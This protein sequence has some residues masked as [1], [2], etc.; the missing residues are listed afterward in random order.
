MR[1]P[2]ANTALLFLIALELLTGFA[3]LTNGSASFRW[4]VWLHGIG[5]FAI[6]A[7]LPWKGAIIASALARRRRLGIPDAAFVVLAVLLV[8][9]L[10]TGLIWTTAGR[11]LAGGYSL[12]TIHIALAAATLGLLVWHVLAMR[13]IFG[14]RGALDRRAFLRLASS[15]AA[16]LVLWRAAGTASTAFGLPGAQRRWTGSYPTGSIGVFPTVSWLADHPPPIDPTN[17]LLVLDGEVA[18][19]LAL[20]Y[21]QID[22]LSTDRLDAILDCTGGWYTNQSWQGIRV[23]RLLEMAG[24]RRTARS[25]VVEA[26]SGYRRQ[27]P[28]AEASRFLLATRVGGEPLSHSHGF[29]VRLVAPNHRGYDWVKWIVRVRVVNTPWFLQPPVPLQ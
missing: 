1:Y 23:A 2:W 4:V 9:T 26:V 7:L 27:F 21:A 14:R 10:G 15:T 5:G 22:G 28:L 13:F 16:G 25:L 29:P 11:L 20:T 6:V 8:A 18:R 19:P 12:L 3:S 17:W 24:A